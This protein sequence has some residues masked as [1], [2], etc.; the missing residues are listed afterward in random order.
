MSAIARAAQRRRV[1]VTVATGPALRSR[2][3]RDG[4]RWREL[5]MS[6]GSNPGVLS[7]RTRRRCRQRRPVGVLRRHPPRDGGDAELPGR[8]PGRRPA[9]GT[10]AGRGGNCR[11]GRGRR[12][13]G[14]PRRSPGVRVHPRP[15]RRGTP[16]HHL[17]PRT[18]HSAADQR[19]V[20]RRAD[21][22]AVDVHPL[23][24]TTSRSCAP[25]VGRSPHRSRSSTTP[26]SRSLAPTVAPVE[27]AFAAHGDDVLYN[28]PGPS[29]PRRASGRTATPACFLGQLRAPRAARR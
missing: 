12:P 9:L 22:M 18:S 15:T 19:R 24:R 10:G 28:S 6:R 16:I 8:G 1:A 2:V 29:A 11:G 7:D 14:D 5:R 20:L 13:A 25:A 23:V 3:E 27:D 26:C 17:R 4:F 21:S